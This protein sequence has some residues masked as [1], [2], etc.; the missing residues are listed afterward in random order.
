[1]TTD[2]AIVAGYLALVDA[3]GPCVVLAHSQ[4]GAFAFKVAEMRPDT[5]K[6]L[7]AVE[8]AAPGDTEKAAILTMPIVAI[9]GDNAKDHPRW[10]GIRQNVGDYVAAIR[11]AGGDAN[12]ID[13]PDFGIMGNTHMMMMDQNSDQVAGVIQDWLAGKGLVD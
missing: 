12:L 10:G 3:V 11:H 4:G 5:V 9:Y 6:A 7:I 13:L 1:V 8:P 2:E